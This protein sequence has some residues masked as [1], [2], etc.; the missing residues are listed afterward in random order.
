MLEISRMRTSQMR[1]DNREWLHKEAL[2]T[3]HLKVTPRGRRI[4]LEAAETIQ[5]QAFS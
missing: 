1:D 4:F 3:M 2:T 5:A